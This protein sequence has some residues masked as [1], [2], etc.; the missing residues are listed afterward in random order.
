MKVCECLWIPPRGIEARRCDGTSLVF[1]W[2]S[3]DARNTQYS[4]AIS[5]EIKNID[6]H[7]W[8]SEGQES[9]DGDTS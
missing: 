6:T 4:R 5:I 3:K 9:D 8:Q 2:T 1:N 7:K